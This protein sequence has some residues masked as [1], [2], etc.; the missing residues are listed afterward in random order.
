M[1]KTVILL[2]VL[3]II[4]KLIGFFRDITLAYYYGAA[5]I[6]DAYIIS[7]TI[8]SLIFGVVATGIATGYIP[9]F[10]RI[11]ENKGDKQAINYTNN[12]INT[13]VVFSTFIIIVGLIF[14]EFLVRIFASGFEGEIF[15]L[16]VI[17]T[18]ITLVGIYFS[19]LNRILSSYLNL[20]K[21]FAIPNIIGIPMSLIVILSIVLSNY[22]HAIWLLAAGYLVALII[23]FFILFYFAYRK[24]FYYQLTLNVK[25]EHI[26]KMFILAVPI[27][28][29]S[30]VHQ[31]NKLIDRTLASRIAEGGISALNYA[32]TLNG[33][34]LGVFV[35][36]ISTVMY[37]TISRMASKENMLGFKHS[38]SQSILGVNLLVIP[39][40]VGILIFSEP[41]VTLL[42]GRGAFDNRA[43]TMT[44]QAFFFYSI[45]ML[46]SGLRMILSRAFYALQDTKTPMI[47][48]ALAMGL[49]IILN[50]ILARFLGLAGLA[51]A[52]S[53]S[54]IFCTTLLF[55]SLRKKIGKLGIKKIINS[56]FKIIIASLLM[57]LCAKLVYQTLLTIF[58][59]QIALIITI[60]I[61]TVIYF[62]F[63]Y[64]L[65]VAEV[66]DIM[67][68]AIKKIRS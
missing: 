67:K 52:T 34:V 5:G 40:T 59:F 20:K 28:L 27:I 43:V 56:L 53:L 8:P 58:S 45:G 41:I 46:G 29:G 31:I 14:T 1:K 61:A 10:S 63:V 37:P 47:N 48:A 2:M 15:Q 42:F 64:F 3:T 9:M 13:L 11:Q 26:R 35:I 55:Y 7:I 17:F 21:Y 49:N 18:R 57:G 23:Q 22:F 54:A 33:F 24:K 6:S 60:F 4:S 62:I 68:M 16:A 44:S 30:S 12:L 65:K 32:H 50:I 38:L 25:D 39:A 51:L 19:L 36:S 66:E